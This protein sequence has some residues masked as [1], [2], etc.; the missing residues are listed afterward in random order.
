MLCSDLISEALVAAGIL[1]AGR[2]AAPQ[3]LSEGFTCLNNLVDAL[4]AEEPLLY[5]IRRDTQAL[6]ATTA[7][8]TVYSGGTFSIPRPL[9]VLRAGVLVSSGAYELPVDVLSFDEW[10][11]VLFKTN[12]SL[13]VERV[14]FDANFPQPSLFVHPIPSATGQTIVLYNAQQLSQFA[15]QGDTVSLPPGFVKLLVYGLGAAEPINFSDADLVAQYTA[16]KTALIALNK[17]NR[18][19]PLV[20]PPAPPQTQQGN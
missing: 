18:H 4:N 5:Y 16:T 11:A 2:T 13:Q 19:E 3:E 6:A 1:G 8:Y 15:T 7:S 10:N 12:Q 14:Y 17:A 9:R 20:V